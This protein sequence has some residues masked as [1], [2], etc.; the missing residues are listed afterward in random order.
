MVKIHNHLYPKFHIRKWI[1]KGGRIYDKEIGQNRDWDIQKDFSLKWYYSLGEMNSE[2]EDR[3]SKFESCI[4]PIIAKIDNAESSITLSGKELELLKL[5]CVLCGSR[6]HFTTEVIKSDGSGVYQSNNYLF[7]LQRTDTQEDAVG[8]TKLIINDFE[9]INALGKDM[10][11]NID[12][13]I[14]TSETSPSFFTMGLHI[15]IGRA[16]TDMLCISD[17][18]CIIENTLD[19]DFLYS[20]VPISP[21]TA[22]FLVKSKYYLDEEHFEYTKKRFGEKYGGG[23]P[24]PYLSVIMGSFLDYDVEDALFCSYSTVRSCVH[25]EEVYIKPNEVSIAKVKIS[26]LPNMIFKQFNSILCEDGEKILFCDEQEMKFAL[27][28]KMD[29]RKV[30]VNWPI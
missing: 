6:Q 15:A 13:Y 28:N 18:V 25:R 19:S 24:D 5:Y 8:L 4:A 9:K 17:R 7:G 30:T 14:F 26:V 11:S 3:L 16:E 12:P 21:R 27:L 29:Y 1:E 22:L 23:K 10:K 20:Y 2:L